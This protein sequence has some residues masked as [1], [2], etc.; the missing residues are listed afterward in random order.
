MRS[1]SCLRR[2]CFGTG[3][4]HAKEFGYLEKSYELAAGRTGERG[5]DAPVEGLR[6]GKDSSLVLDT[7]QVGDVD[8]L[9]VL[10]EGGS[11][12]GWHRGGER[13]TPKD[14][15][16]ERK[17]ELTSGKKSNGRWWGGEP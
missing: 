4:C 8:L 15:R 16:E 6:S 1:A 17:K 11:G 13:M 2:A 3:S 12:T 5:E 10:L 14:E 7:G 9:D